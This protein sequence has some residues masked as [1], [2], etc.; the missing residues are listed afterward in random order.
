MF[1]LDACGVLSSVEFC[2]VGT[3]GSEFFIC[4][5]SFRSFIDTPTRIINAIANNA[6]ST[7]VTT[8]E[9]CLQALVDSE[10]DVR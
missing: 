3:A 10:S 1:F 9:I 6:D 5:L 8:V 4:A 2:V 7:Y